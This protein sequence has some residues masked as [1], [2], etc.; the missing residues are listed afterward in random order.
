MSLKEY[1]L[2]YV[3]DF[4][5]QEVDK[6]AEEN[7]TKAAELVGQM[8]SC[9]SRKNFGKEILKKNMESDKPASNLVMLMRRK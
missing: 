4:L 9:K 8:S 6:L 2:S 7:F 5:G 3:T 1:S